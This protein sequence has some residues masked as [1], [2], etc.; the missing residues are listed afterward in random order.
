M[1]PLESRLQNI[2]KTK[3]VLYLRGFLG[4]CQ[5]GGRRHEKPRSAGLANSACSRSRDP[6]HGTPRLHR[7]GSIPEAHGS[8]NAKSL[9][10]GLLQ[11]PGVKSGSLAIPGPP[12]PPASSPGQVGSL[13]GSFPSLPVAPSITTDRMSR[14]MHSFY[15]ASQQLITQSCP[16]PAIPWTVTCQ[17]PLSLEFSRQEYRSGL[18]LPPPGGSSQ[19]RDRTYISCVSRVGRQMLYHCATQAANHSPI[20]L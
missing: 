4:G 17:V 13:P 20:G 10:Q 16:T 1:Q 19:P 15:A 6:G 5:L 8:S 11:N 12:S 2:P 9:S 14:Q 3:S 18:P 7:P